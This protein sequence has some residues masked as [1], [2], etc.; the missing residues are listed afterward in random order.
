MMGTGTFALPTFQ[1]L[2][3]S[4]HQLVG[5]VTQPDRVL[6]GKLAHP[7]PM[8]EAAIAA[9]VDVFQPEHVN[10]PAALDQLRHYAADV[11]IVAAYGQI[12]S[13]ELLSIPPLG[14]FNLHGSL[15][16]KYRGA[17]PIQFA[18]LNGE[19]ETG[20]TLFQIEPKLDAG[21]IVGVVKTNIGAK[22][23]S[24]ELHDRMA[25]LGGPLT[26][27][28]L[29]ELE[30]DTLTKTYQDTS[31][32]TKAP[33]ILKESG[34]IDW[35]KTTTEISWHIRGMQPW[36]MPFTD[37]NVPERKTICMQILDV[38]PYAEVSQKILENAVPGACLNVD[39]SRLIIRTGD[40]ALEIKTLQ[41]SG[42]R[43]MPAS[44]FLRGTSVKDAYAN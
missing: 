12:L 31:Q 42:K 13:A 2:I 23:T 19:T 18:V 4:Q 9:G 20:I 32:V 28:M 15:L 24:G 11:F 30:T 14:A 17:A 40:G 27:K 22:E 8:K 26:L 6:R 41:P 35:S 16:P 33:K 44:D 39:E 5:L 7:H 34:R 38:D 1:D 21:P 36:P 37:L 3:A 43:A 25:P 10:T 29:Q